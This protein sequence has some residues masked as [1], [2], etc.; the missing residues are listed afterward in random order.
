MTGVSVIMIARNGADFIASALASVFE[1]RVQPLE[2]LVIDGISTDATAAL[3]A[4]V[5]NVTVV[6]Q[7]STGI[8][9][10]YNE[11]V[12]MARGDLLAFLSHD[13]LWLPGKLDKQT[14]LM[15]SDPDLLYSFTL[16]Q[17][18]LEPGHTPP[19]GFRATLLGGPVPGFLMETMM[20]R[21]G[22]FE[23][24]GGFSD[25][26]ALGNDSDWFMRA[27]DLGLKM[28]VLPEVLLRKRI[29]GG[30]TS[31]THARMGHDLLTALRGSL[32]RRRMA[33]T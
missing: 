32:A 27:R 11:G 22:A 13:D 14:E 8:A 18:F 1:S 23:R 6:P 21:R 25:A 12:A 3:A 30:N 15:R 10:A 9:G 4:A 33:G 28:A 7:R 31:L 20:A 2:V 24:V 29:H 17:H 5:P 16:V 19:S 26:Y